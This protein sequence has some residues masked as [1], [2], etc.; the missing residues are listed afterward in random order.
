SSDLAARANGR[1]LPRGQRHRR[2]QGGSR[3]DAGARRR[4]AQERGGRLQRL[5]GAPPRARLGPPARRRR[6]GGG[7][8]AG[9]GAPSLAARRRAP[10]LELLPAV[11]VGCGLRRD[12]RRFSRPH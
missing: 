7:R 10:P 5:R 9:R 8:R 1:P 3:A 4:G 6:G 2:L 12:S 11:C